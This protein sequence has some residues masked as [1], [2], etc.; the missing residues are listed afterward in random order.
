MKTQHLALLFAVGGALAAPAP[1]P[2]EQAAQQGQV[3][4]LGQ[5]AQLNQNE[6]AI[7]NEQMI[8]HGQAVQELSVEQRALLTELAQQF[9]QL[10]ALLGPLGG[11][12][13]LLGNL[14][15]IGSIVSLLPLQTILHHLPILGPLL[16]NLFT[17]LIGPPPST[18][19]GGGGGI[20]I[21]G[22]GI[23]LPFPLSITPSSAEAEANNPI[24]KREAES[25]QDVMMAFAHLVME[26]QDQVHQIQQIIF[27]KADAGPEA[28]TNALVQPLTTLRDNL[29]TGVSSVVSRAGPG[30]LLSGL[31]LVGDLLGGGSTSALGLVGK[32]LDT[33]LQLVQSLLGGSG[34]TGGATGLTGALGGSVLNDLLG[35]TGL[36]SLVGG[37]LLSPGSPLTPVISQILAAVTGLLPGAPATTSTTTPRA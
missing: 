36:G 30:G 31:P 18:T 16:G 8:Q 9:P 24:A 7:Q 2:E 6:Q 27:D 22:T 5:H 15:L 14:P 17:P 19:G 33:L 32:L 13:G 26:T 34:P 11:S 29:Q 35:K 4:Q 20:T 10:N 25:Q 23:T 12:G 28:L 37:A 21:P 1:V 3:A